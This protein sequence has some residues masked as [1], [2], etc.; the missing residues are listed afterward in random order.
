MHDSLRLSAVGLTLVAGWA[1]S[2]LAQGGPEY[3]LS[4][5]GTVAAVQVD[6]PGVEFIQAGQTSGA[7]KS[8]TFKT[9]SR[10]GGQLDVKFNPTFS[11]TAQ[12]LAKHGGDGSDR[13]RVEWAFG[14]AKLGGG[15]TLRAGRMGAPFF[16]VSDFREVGFA[17]HWLRTPSDVY[18]QVFLR[19]FDGA[20]L[21]FAGDVAGVPVTAQLIVGGT[22]AT[23]ARNKVDYKSQVGLNLTAEVVDGVTLRAGTIEGKL[24]GLFSRALTSPCGKIRIPINES[25]DDRSQIEEYLRAYRGEGIQHVAMGAQD[26]FAS[27]AGL[28]EAG[29]SFMPSPPATYYERVD[30][31][32]P[33]HGVD[34][35]ALERL[36]ILIDG[37]GVVAGGL[38]RVL[39]QI[40]TSTVI[41]PIFF[42][43][44]ERRGDAGFGEGNFRALFESI[45]ADQLRRGV[46]TAGAA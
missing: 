19:S 8:A 1:G 6:Q 9:D 7:G 33:G 10:L 34:R 31:R 18:G 25:A 26:I 22:T 4:G 40:F 11:A 24:T 44:I 35:A 32:V 3:R 36:G 21:N 37:E 46:I 29:L 20:D 38:T 15:F 16:A 30:S 45:E 5:F 13:P 17:N 39:L 27:V 14:K 12:L 41:G 2:C 42:E 23:N 28:R 43:I